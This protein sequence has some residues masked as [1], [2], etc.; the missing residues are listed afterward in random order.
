MVI[1]YFMYKFILFKCIKRRP[2][3]QRVD[4]NI[5]KQI[6]KQKL[7]LSVIILTVLLVCR[8]HPS[9][10]PMPYSMHRK[11]LIYRRIFCNLEYQIFQTIAE[12]FHN[13][14]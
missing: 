1:K 9:L 5:Q 12:T 3:S 4:Q 6:L 11:T 13:T 2:K 10:Y 14:P 7:I 8:V